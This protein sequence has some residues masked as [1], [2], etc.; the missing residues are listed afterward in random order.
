MNKLKPTT[1]YILEG[2]IPYTNAN[3]KLTYKPNEFFNELE[4]ISRIKER[5]LRSAYYRAVKEGLV[6]VGTDN[7]PRLTPKGISRIK[8][9]KPQ[10][11]GNSRLIIIFDIPEEER[12][13]RDHLRLLLKEL[14]F[15]KLQQ[16]VWATDYDHRDYLAAEIEANDLKPYVQVF[17]AVRIAI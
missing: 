8:K 11:L 15:H 1:K 13:K 14:S 5:S 17:E 10:K 9:Y 4:R 2:F 7:V 16:S 3:L 6:E 12:H